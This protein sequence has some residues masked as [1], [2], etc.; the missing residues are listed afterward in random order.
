MIKPMLAHVF[1]KRKKHII[2]PCA[3]QPKLDGIRCIYDGKGGLWTRTGKPIVSAPHVLKALE[4]ETRVLDGE[5]YNHDYRDNFEELVS[6]IRQQTKVHPKHQEIQ[7]HIYD[8]PMNTGFLYRQGL[9]SELEYSP[10][11]KIVETGVVHCEEELMDYNQDCLEKG[12]EGSMVR[13]LHTEYE[14][15]RSNS[16]QKIKTPLFWE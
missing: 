16:L 8:V 12:Y 1:E 9:L 6:M 13:N 2:C 15:K 10:F 3:T 5:L 11:I 4:G 7:F 14:Y